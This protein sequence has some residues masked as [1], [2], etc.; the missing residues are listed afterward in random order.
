MSG[1]AAAITRLLTDDAKQHDVERKIVLVDIHDRKCY[2][3][4]HDRD[5][6]KYGQ[7]RVE[8][9]CRQ[10][11]DRR[12]PASAAATPRRAATSA[13]HS[14]ARFALKQAAPVINRAEFRQASARARRRKRARIKD[15]CRAHQASCHERAPPSPLLLLLPAFSMCADERSM[16]RLSRPHINANARSKKFATT[17]RDLTAKICA[18]GSKSVCS[19]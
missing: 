18:S 17:K 7:T 1:A 4:A 12:P 8:H 16:P 5:E 15:D 6:H 14:R 11:R 2:A 3:E 19:E 9:G 10:R 13:R